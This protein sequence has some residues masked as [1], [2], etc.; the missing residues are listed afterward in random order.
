MKIILEKK[1][2]CRQH[3]TAAFLMLPL[4]ALYFVVGLLFLAKKITPTSHLFIRKKK[5]ASLIIEHAKII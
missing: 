2:T 5:K 1:D 4:I 3:A